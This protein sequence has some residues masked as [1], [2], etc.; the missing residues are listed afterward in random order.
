[1]RS[2]SLF[3][4]VSAGALGFLLIAHTELQAGPFWRC[5][6]PYGSVY[7]SYASRSGTYSGASSTTEPKD[8]TSQSFYNPAQSLEQ[9]SAPRSAYVP[10]RRPARS[11]FYDANDWPPPGGP[12][13]FDQGQGWAP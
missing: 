10:A 7:Y 11:R 8:T 9:N 2:A 4:G 6:A 12:P 5:R 1:M 13:G 3:A